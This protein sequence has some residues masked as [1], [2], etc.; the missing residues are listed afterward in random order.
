VD[1]AEGGVGG[2][3]GFDSGGVG[4][5]DR[6]ADVVGA[7]EGDDAAFDHRDRV[8]PVPDLF[9]D[10]GAVGWLCSAAGDSEVEGRG[11]GGGAGRGGGRGRE[12][13]F[14][15]SGGKCPRWT[16]SINAAGSMG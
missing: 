14:A 6:A 9:A 1:A 11:T 15:A 8:P 7:D 5:E 10:Q 16:V 4:G 2:G 12:G 13:A 3:P